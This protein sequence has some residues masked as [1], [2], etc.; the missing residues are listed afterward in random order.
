MN[1]INE[2]QHLTQKPGEYKAKPVKRVFIPKPGKA[3]KRPLGIPTLT[4]RA[5]QAVYLYSIDPLV[6]ETSDANSYGFRPYRGAREATAKIR[7]TLGKDYSPNWLLD[8]DIE[9]CFDRINH[10]WLLEHVPI[11]DR[12]VL[13][14]WL[15]AGVETGTGTELIGLGVPQGGVISPTLSNIA[16]N[17]LEKC[18]QE[19]TVHMVPRRERTKVYLIR[20]A[21]DFIV[22]GA[23][24]E[25]LDTARSGIEAFLEP[26]GLRLHPGKTRVVEINKGEPFAFLGFEFSKKPL[27]YKLNMPSRKDRTRKRLVVR[28][29]KE[30]IKKLK[31]NV[32]ATLTPGR[33][34]SGVIKDLNPILRGWSN[35]FRVG[36]HSPIVFK[37]LGNWV[38]R[39]MLIWAQRKHS[40]RNV[41][42]I[43]DRYINKSKWRSNHWCDKGTPT[44]HLLDISTVTHMFI[45]TFPKDLNPYTEADKKKL[46]ARNLTVA[47][48]K[49][50]NNIRK[51]L[52]KRDGGL[53]P[54]CET[55]IMETN[56][57][58][59][60][61][62]LT[63]ISEGGTWKLDNLVLLHE[64][65]H[66][67]VTH[68]EAL[69]NE[70]RESYNSNRPAM[71]A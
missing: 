27:N 44:R 17:G 32:K 11:V 54:V 69:K 26:R 49:E 46:D 12:E 21:D 22:T 1:A 15:R 4:D 63:G 65:C 64:A 14:T 33:P 35:Y 62:H 59:E 2:L 52:T 58:I 30:N 50:R 29:S 25:I 41:E 60:L 20:Y 37:S 7:D 70:L 10:N 57:P 61:H 13:Q 53:C 16:L 5:M 3:E 43:K 67:S 8:A 66:K 40:T 47:T 68:N 19:C 6:E 18:A 38:W 56:E 45:P 51:N 28:P 24:R 71:S 55:S 31:S 9:K 48:S 36:R 34:I 42:W 23:S 39:R